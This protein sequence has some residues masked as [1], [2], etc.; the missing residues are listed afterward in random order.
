MGMVRLSEEGCRFPSGQKHESWNRV[1]FSNSHDYLY[2]GSMT[3]K[4]DVFQ[5]T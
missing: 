3:E 1:T 2:V 5:Q 4:T